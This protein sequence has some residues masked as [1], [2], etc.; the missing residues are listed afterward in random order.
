MNLLVRLPLQIVR[1]AAGAGFTV[2]R[3]AVGQLREHL[4]GGDGNGDG[5][6]P[7]PAAP[8]QARRADA[9]GPRTTAPPAAAP[10]PAAP[11]AAPAAP[12]LRESEPAQSATQEPPPPVAHEPRHIDVE[13]EEVASFGPERDAHATIT[14]Q[15][16]WDGYD[17]QAAQEIVDR[18]RD[19]D[20]TT[21]AA[22]LLY[23]GQGKNRKT[24]IAAAGGS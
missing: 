10:T 13:A 18:V 23:E 3:F 4:P 20:D 14:V 11:T 16:P 17:D 7:A 24:V 19:A 22:V 2:G 8:P 6:A 21:K 12:E 15:A 5:H 9:G 1:T